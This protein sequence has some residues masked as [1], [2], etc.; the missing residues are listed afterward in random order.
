FLDAQYLRRNGGAAPEKHLASP[1]LT[2][3]ELVVGR[4]QH[5]VPKLI[6]AGGFARSLPRVVRAVELRVGVEVGQ[7]D[8]RAL[9]GGIET[10]DVGN[11]PMRGGHGGGHLPSGGES[12]GSG[13]LEAVELRLSSGIVGQREPLERAAPQ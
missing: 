9:F 10:V 6:A 2:T 5:A 3:P 13:D 12:F 4:H 11:V 7:L 8:T 1:R